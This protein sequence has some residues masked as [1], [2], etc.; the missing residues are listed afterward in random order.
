VKALG[1]F[2]FLLA[3]GL[4]LAVAGGVLAR[5]FYEVVLLGWGSL[6]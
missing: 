6:G 4:A 5:L 1:S 2:V 3:V